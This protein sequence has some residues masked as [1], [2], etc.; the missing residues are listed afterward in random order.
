MKTLERNKIEK[1]LENPWKKKRLFWRKTAQ[2]AQPRARA[3]SARQLSQTGGPHL[4]HP[5][6]LA[7]SSLSP[8]R[9]R[10]GLTC[11]R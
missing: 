4:S 1:K 9:C 5:L 8:P 11:R 10:V 7:H 6:V 2:P 3:A